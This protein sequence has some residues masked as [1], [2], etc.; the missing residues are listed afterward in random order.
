[1]NVLRRRRKGQ[2]MKW[3][4]HKLV[5]LCVVYSMTGDVVPTAAAVVGSVLPDLLEFRIGKDSAGLIPHRT[6]THY[7]PIWIAAFA[8]LWLMYQST[9]S[10]SWIIYAGMFAVLGGLLHL[11]EDALSKGGIPFF[12]PY[13]K[14]HGA[15]VYKVGTTSEEALAFGLV[16]FFLCIASVRGYFKVEHAHQQAMILHTIAG[17]FL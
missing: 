7:P 8:S 15:G 2:R 1:M 9:G 5:T 3:R 14:P 11:A 10:A 4:N 13:G 12:S 6:I 16:F 17:R